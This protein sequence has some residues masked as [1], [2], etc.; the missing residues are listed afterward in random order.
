MTCGRLVRSALLLHT[1]NVETRTLQ[2]WRPF[3]NHRMVHK[4]P[5]DT[6]L[7]V[8][9][10]REQHTPAVV[11]RQEAAHHAR[12]DMRSFNYRFCSSQGFL[13][14]TRPAGVQLPNKIRIRSLKR[15]NDALI[16]KTAA[17][18]SDQSHFIHNV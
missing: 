4:E 1:K 13:E 17:V 16:P 8:L 18:S 7:E 11:Q 14:S 6:K 3:L 5:H 2:Q 12:H 10:V 9:V 15:E